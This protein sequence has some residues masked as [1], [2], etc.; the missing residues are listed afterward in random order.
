MV[1]ELDVRMGAYVV[2]QRDF[3]WMYFVKRDGHLGD[4]CDECLNFMET[5]LRV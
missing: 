5:C 1:G 3:V 4:A 2:L